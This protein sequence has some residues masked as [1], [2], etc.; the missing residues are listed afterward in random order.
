M[1]SD[2][3]NEQKVPPSVRVVLDPGVVCQPPGLATGRGDNEGS[4][5]CTWAFVAPCP[6]RCCTW[7]SCQTRRW[8]RS[9]GWCVGICMV[10]IGY[11]SDAGPHSSRLSEHSEV[12]GRSIGSD[13]G[14]PCAQTYLRTWLS[15]LDL[16]DLRLGIFVVGFSGCALIEGVSPELR[17]QGVSDT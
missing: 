13:P 12:D 6:A 8:P 11:T 14:S 4:L 10:S 16:F 7:P 9:S 5:G 2:L 17:R 15:D 3:G 1:Q